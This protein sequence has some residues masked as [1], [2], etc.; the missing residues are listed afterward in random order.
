MTSRAPTI[1]PSVTPADGGGTAP[2]SAPWVHW[3][4]IHRYVNTAWDPE[5]SPHHSVI[6]LTGSGKSYLAINGILRPMCRHDRVLL[7]DSKGD[8]KLVSSQGRPVRQIENRPWYT[9]IGKKP[10][11]YDHWQR[12]VVYGNRHTERAK[13]QAQVA[14]A[15]ERVY[16]EGDWVVF[17]DEE[18][19]MTTTAPGL[20]LGA[21]T[22]ELRR[23]G[24]SRGISVI[25]ATQSPVQVRRS[26]YDQ[27]SFAWI[28]RIRDR[29]RQKRLLEI[30]GMT[31]DEL[32]FISELKRQQWLLAADN[33]EYFA[34][35]KVVSRKGVQ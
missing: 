28:G 19:D 4:H 11:A 14:K 16:N 18:I 9:N 30:G 27:A 3:S 5:H 10:K 8:D 24:R 17:F 33:G 22:D 29:D 31:K 32:P 1:P 7:I 23:M 12:L 15:L 21:Y 20:G 2:I 35:S 25:G 13:A 26:F 6:G 34:R